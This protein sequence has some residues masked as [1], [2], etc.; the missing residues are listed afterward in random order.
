MDIL[1]SQNQKKTKPPSAA[2][3][4]E[5]EFNELEEDRAKAEREATRAQSDQRVEELVRDLDGKIAAKQIELN[6]KKAEISGAT[7]H[8]KPL[9]QAE[10]Y[11][12]E[13]ELNLLKAQ[14]DYLTAK[15]EEKEAKGKEVEEKTL[16]LAEKRDALGKLLPEM[17]DTPGGGD[18]GTGTTLDGAAPAGIEP[19]TGSSDAP[20][21][22][23]PADS[24]YKGST[25]MDNIRNGLNE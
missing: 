25:G 4:K 11:V 12:F 18:T 2:Q 9:K 6:A 15:P 14:L 23:Y 8:E 20:A 5:E 22:S 16:D 10:A 24:K 3:A 1:I 13:A 19:P 21:E 17:E 7:P